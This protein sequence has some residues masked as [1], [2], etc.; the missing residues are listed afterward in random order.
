LG[1]REGDKRKGGRSR[2][3]EKKISQT[4]ARDNKGQAVGHG[5]EDS[6]NAPHKT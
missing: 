4:R 6:T 1:E 2:R 5:R 3:G